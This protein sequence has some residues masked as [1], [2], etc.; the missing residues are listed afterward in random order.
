MIV[1][2]VAGFFLFSWTQRGRFSPG[3]SGSVAPPYSAATLEGDTISLAGLEGKV[4]LLN[5]WATW[6][7]PCVREM[8]A[9]QRLHE[10]LGPRGLEV[11]AVSV[12]TYVPAIRAGGAD[13]RG[14]ADELGLT[15]TILHDPDGRIERLFRATGLPVTVVIDREG[16]IRERVFGAREWDEPQHASAIEKLLAD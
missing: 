6:C 5:I 14:F 13:I 4:V 8:P 10:R 7:K 2:L 9:L 1:A 3:D 11:V 12:D 15:F 16:R